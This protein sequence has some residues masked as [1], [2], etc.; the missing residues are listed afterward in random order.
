MLD[1]DFVPIDC[2][3]PEVAVDGVEAYPM[4]AWNEGEGFFEVTAQFADISRFT[5]EITSRPDV[6][7]AGVPRFSYFKSGNVVRLPTVDGQ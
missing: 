5:R 4:A 7:N 2:P 6:G 3:A 1:P